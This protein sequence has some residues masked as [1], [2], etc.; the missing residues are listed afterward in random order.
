M[1][2]HEYYKSQSI[3]P[4]KNL[5]FVQKILEHRVFDKQFDK[6]ENQFERSPRFG[7]SEK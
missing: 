2:N 4:T 5:I 3:D 6:N 1:I 7:N